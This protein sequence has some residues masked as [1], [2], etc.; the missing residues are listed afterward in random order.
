MN[1]PFDQDLI[2]AAC[3]VVMC[4]FIFVMIKWSIEE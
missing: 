3:A 2:D 4:I 1:I